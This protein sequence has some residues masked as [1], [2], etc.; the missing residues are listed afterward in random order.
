MLG[1]VDES[2][3]A[4]V[5]ALRGDELLDKG[6]VLNAGTRAAHL[7]PLFDGMHIGS[8]LIVTHVAAVGH[9]VLLLPQALHLLA[10]FVVLIL[11]E[12]DPVL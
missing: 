1:V 6:I 2:S 12:V 5:L 8:T 11:L 3:H 4:H 9:E 10:V 7:I